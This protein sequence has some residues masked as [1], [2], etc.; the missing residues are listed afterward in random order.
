MDAIPEI[1]IHGAIEEQ[2]LRSNEA[3]ARSA[4]QIELLGRTPEKNASAKPGTQDGIEA[5]R[6]SVPSLLQAYPSLN[7][8]W[9]FPV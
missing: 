4:L 6:F 3:L 9:R 2:A 1:Q 7:S 8:M 5:L